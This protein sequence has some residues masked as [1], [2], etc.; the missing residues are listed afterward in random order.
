MG[1]VKLYKDIGFAVIGALT[2]IALYFL[3]KK[4]GVFG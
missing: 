2:G 3:A 1:D 4:I